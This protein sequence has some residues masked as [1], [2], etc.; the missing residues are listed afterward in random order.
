MKPI[1][2]LPVPQ[3][4]PGWGS[5][6]KAAVADHYTH[7]VSMD[8]HGAHQS[9]RAN[10][11]D[12]DPNYKD[13]F[14]QPLL[15]MTFD[16]QDNDIKM[17]QFMHDRMRKIAVAMNPKEIIGA[18]KVQGTHF[19]TTVYQTTHMNGGAIMGE[20]PKTSAV[21]RYL[22]SW[23]VPNVFVPGASAFPQGLGYNPTGMVAA[24]TYWSAKAIREQY[25][26]NR[27]RWCRHKDDGDEKRIT[28]AVPAGYSL[29]RDGGRR[30]A[31]DLIKRGEYLARAGTAS[32]ATPAKRVNPLPAG[33]RW[34]PRSAPSIPLISP[35]IKRPAS[36]AT[37]MTTSR[38]QCVMA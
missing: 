36:A 14:G 13:A 12:L 31:G 9:Y 30:P 6:W 18:P 28:G 35:R 26:K 2:G 17:S 21:N 3:G 5:K 27:D 4:T 16:W 10:Y 23:D 38:R 22:Q 1:S 11:L 25:L 34:Q 37:A 32:P 24:L 8:A 19:D 33:W 7:H 29:W 15:R 20:D